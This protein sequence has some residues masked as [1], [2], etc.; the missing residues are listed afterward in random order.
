MAKRV[1]DILPPE[2]LKEEALEKEKP[3]FKL[4][5][6]RL[7]K[8]LI[9]LPSIIFIVL[10]SL[11]LL[12]FKFSKAEIKIWPET[13][14]PA[15]KT[16]LT[17]E[18]KVENPDFK[19]NILPGKIF[20]IEK[21]FS[22]EFSSS[23]KSLKKAEGIIRL[24]NASTTKDETWLAGTRFVSSDGKLF[25]SKDK[26]FVPGAK[27]KNEKIVP[28]F[29]DVPVVAAEG[30]SDYNIGPSH[31]SILAFK[32]TPRYYKFYGE[33]FQPMTGGGEVS[34]VK[35]EDLE[36]AENILIEKAK[37]ELKEILKKEIPSD[38]VFLADASEIKILDKFSLARPGEEIEKFNFQLRAKMSTISFKKEDSEKLVDE[39]I[40]SQIEKGKSIF[41]ESLKMEYLP[42]IINFELGK[43]N[44]S[45]NFSVKI[46]PEID[47]QSLKRALIGK[48]LAETK[49]FLENQ[50]Q[51][52]RTEIH[53]FPFW[54]K[55]IPKDVEKIE[56][57]YPIID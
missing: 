18:T 43:I 49:I 29:V 48:S 2:K 23:G 40:L 27:I 16:R 26:I 19:N 45:L 30:G 28:S 22:E 57:D 15:F 33:S 36:R 56:I 42:E 50:P 17:A 5:E 1:F 35:K 12:S 24:Y 4:P 8:K 7:G 37:G 6:I 31:F 13:E 10:I 3:K 9:F 44:I 11:F 52:I 38:F 20:E 47:S 51:I 41:K 14:T 55:N 25:K 53:L 21:T 46:Y 32:G 34:Q 39:L 54:L